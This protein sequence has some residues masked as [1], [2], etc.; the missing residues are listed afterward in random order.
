[1]Q[2][3]ETAVAIFAAILASAARAFLTF[4]GLCGPESGYGAG[5]SVNSRKATSKPSRFSSET[6]TKADAKQ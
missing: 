4:E 6:G 1:L 5:F 3:Q 2:G